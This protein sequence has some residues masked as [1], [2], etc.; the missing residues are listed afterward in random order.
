ML[1]T[2]AGSRTGRNDF[3]A[4]GFSSVLRERRI[5]RTVLNR[6]ADEGNPP[7]GMAMGCAQML[8]P[9]CSRLFR[10]QPGAGSVQSG[11]IA[12]ILPQRA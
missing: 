6:L 9:G 2:R 10:L 4:L 5:G 7:V 1:G 3:I 11:A 12:K 8:K